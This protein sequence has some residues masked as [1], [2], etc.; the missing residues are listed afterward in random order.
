MAPPAPDAV[1][2]A[3]AAARREKAMANPS[4][5]R[6][7]IT[8]AYDN[9]ISKVM[10]KRKTVV[11][12]TI[13]AFIGTLPIVMLLSVVRPAVML[14]VLLGIFG[15][16]YL[17]G[18]GEQ[19]SKQLR[20]MKKMSSRGPIFWV[21]EAVNRLT[22]RV[23][24]K[25]AGAKLDVV[26]KAPSALGTSV[27]G[28]Q[29]AVLKWIPTPSSQFSTETYEVQ[30]RYAPR[31]P[32]ALGESSSAA[33]AAVESEWMTLTDELGVATLELKPLTADIGY[34]VRV[35]AVNSKGPSEWITHA[36][37]TK[38]APIKD[39]GRE[40][41]GGVAPGY[42]WL[43]SLK[44]DSLSATFGPLPAGTRAKQLEVSV[45]P[46][47]IKVKLQGAAAPL[48]D[49]E[50]FGTVDSEDVEWELQDAAKAGI[51][52]A[53]E[54][55]IHLTKTH[56]Q[57]AGVSTPPLWPSLVKGHPEID[58]TLLKRVEKSMEE[59]M[60]DLQ[61]S[62]GMHAMDGMNYAKHV[63]EGMDGAPGMG[64]PQ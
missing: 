12:A 36:F 1:S 14:P 13:F 53:R 28:A 9:V 24:R 32:S 35:R 21:A 11:R 51:P 50:F 7:A 6:K 61:K 49:G 29:R 25:S 20:W 48:L 26:P 3:M 46:T 64:G 55:V 39:D 27:R 30:M 17:L 18:A 58:V 57:P 40:R 59:M 8:W 63:R 16:L 34:E 42:L 5:V 43:Q 54:L 60:A 41:A 31:L 44:D 33:D 62:T 19:V 15:A 10:P 4:A 45:M 22:V 37:A 52:G 47:T 23:A 38:Q 56:K 2:E